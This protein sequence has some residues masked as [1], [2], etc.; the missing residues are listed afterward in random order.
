MTLASAAPSDG[1]MAAVLL[2]LAVIVVAARGLGW[3]FG[4]FQ[5]PV[6]LGEILAG[7]V[8]G[9]SVIGAL[10]GN[11][12]EFL[13]PGDTR[14]FLNVLANLGLV[15]FM[16]LVGLELDLQSLRRRSRMAMTI[17]VSSVAFPFALGV[18]L[19]LV[20]YA[21]H[22]GAPGAEVHLLPFVLFIGTA[23]SV[24]AFPV[25]ARILADRGLG[26]TE[27][28]SLVLTCAALEDLGA[29]ALLTGALAVAASQSLW[30]LP[31]I[32][33][34]AV[35]FAGLLVVLGRPLLGRLLIRRAPT[36]IDQRALLS[37]AICGAGLSACVTAAIGIHLVL[38][39]FLFGL[40]FPRHPGVRARLQRALEPLAGSVLL[41][42]F[43]ILP[44]LRIDLHSIGLAGARD[45]L[46]ILVVATVGKLAG[47]TGAARALGI[48]WRDSLAIGAL[49]NT[50]G[51]MELIVLNVG[52]SAG[53]I[54]PELYGLFVVMAI[55]TTLM[56]GPMLRLLYPDG[57]A[58]RTLVTRTPTSSLRFDPVG[59]AGVPRKG[60]VGEG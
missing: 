41:P 11:P 16:F 33:A 56:S 4:R 1:S 3:V 27:L 57:R 28:G 6:V 55:A 10:P 26:R 42:V 59:R 38:G 17:S 58:P 30:Q 20:L 45:L 32:L 8:L 22:H 31:R 9:P 51:L 25:L 29:W 34:S 54:D 40:S 52:L 60:Y 49:I 46:L 39:A 43:F 35:L 44:G 15:V 2:S 53:V 7:I 37:V 48:R 18:P 50:R 47:A 5:Q 23:V 19:A 13:I 24:T 14:P 36:V 21:Q 12:T